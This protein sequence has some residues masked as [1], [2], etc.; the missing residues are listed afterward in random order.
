MEEGE[1]EMLETSLEF[2]I[3]DIL[4]EHK[5]NYGHSLQ[6]LTSIA[7]LA[8]IDRGFPFERFKKAMNDIMDHYEETWPIG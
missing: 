8:S 6:V 5:I 3:I 1:N 7:A 4:T 2:K